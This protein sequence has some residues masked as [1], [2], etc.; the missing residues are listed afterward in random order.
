MIWKPWIETE[1]P[2]T[3][4]PAVREL[5]Q[6]TRIPSS[7]LPPDKVRLHSLTPEIA[8]AIYRLNRMI[9]DNAGGLTHREQEIAALVVSSFN[10]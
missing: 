3:T 7:G 10:G 2:D 5:Y 1:P 6:H 9:H 4:T 8:G